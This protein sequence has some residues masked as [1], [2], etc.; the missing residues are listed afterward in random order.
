MDFVACVLQ[1]H[2][3]LC[4]VLAGSVGYVVEVSAV[5]L[6]SELRLDL[7]EEQLFFTTLPLDLPI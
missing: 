2:V 1:L 6:A 3:D 5:V 4:V 7:P